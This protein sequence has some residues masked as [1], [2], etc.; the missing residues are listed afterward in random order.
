MSSSSYGQ[1]LLLNVLGFFG[2]KFD[3]QGKSKKDMR[4]TWTILNQ[5]TERTSERHGTCQESTAPT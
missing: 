2:E 4:R 5:K 1:I 3:F